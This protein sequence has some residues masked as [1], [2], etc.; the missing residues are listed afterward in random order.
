MKVRFK[1][2]DNFHAKLPVYK[3]PGDSGMDVFATE[4]RYLRPGEHAMFSLGI[5]AE[6]PAGYEL[7]VRPRSGLAS[8]GV[9]AAFGTIDCKY[10]GEIK[11]NLFN[12]GSSTYRVAVGDRIAQLVLSP[13]TCAEIVETDTIDEATER[14]TGGFGSTGA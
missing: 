13:V 3:H 10:R 1:L 9:I 5:A 2:L 6:I 4:E 14:G 12:H 8:N 7:Q 11:V